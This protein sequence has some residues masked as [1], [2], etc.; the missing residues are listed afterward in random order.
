M[1]WKANKDRV[2]FI[3]Q[4]GGPFTEVSSNQLIICSLP[5]GTMK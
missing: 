1:G 3:V 2:I 4:A 5:L